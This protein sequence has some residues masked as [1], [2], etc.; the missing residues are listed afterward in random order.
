ML[1]GNW[2]TL[3]SMPN[4]IQSWPQQQLSKS[5]LKLSQANP[6]IDCCQTTRSATLPAWKCTVISYWQVGHYICWHAR[7]GLALVYGSYP[8][9]EIRLEFGYTKKHKPDTWRESETREGYINR[10]PT[11]H[12]FIALS[13]ADNWVLFPVLTDIKISMAIICEEY[14]MLTEITQNRFHVKGKHIKA[15][16]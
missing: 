1:F 4:K 9:A 13:M 6:L 16:R 11:W 14:S 3:I 7:Q 2:T 15:R 10:Q 5:S 12:V 8:R